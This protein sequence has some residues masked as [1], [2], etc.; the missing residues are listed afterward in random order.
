M[1]GVEALVSEVLY[2]SGLRLMEALRLRVKDL[3]FERRELTVRDGKGSKDRRTMSSVP[4]SGVIPEDQHR[5]RRCWRVAT[6][7]TMVGQMF[8][9]A[10]QVSTAFPTH[11]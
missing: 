1:D 3:D 5:L 10:L 4:P 2:G 8:C 6:A 11:K 7:V 9:S